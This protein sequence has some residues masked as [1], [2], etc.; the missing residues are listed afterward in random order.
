MGADPREAR[1]LK[2]R[3]RAVTPKREVVPG[4]ALAPKWSI[5][6]VWAFLLARAVVG[7]GGLGRPE[8]PKRPPRAAKGVGVEA[9]QN[10]A[11]SVARDGPGAGAIDTEP[12]L[13]VGAGPRKYARG[14][15]ATKA[16]GGRPGPRVGPAGGGAAKYLAV[17][18]HLPRAALRVAGP[19]GA[20]CAPLAG[21]VGV[22]EGAR[23]A[24]PLD[25][26]NIAPE[27]RAEADRRGVAGRVGGIGVGG[28]A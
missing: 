17:T 7:E 12:T 25:A 13:A 15:A 3:P 11:P 28:A 27:G 10:A 20:A 8:D 9:P 1:G 16:I 4:Q 2:A 5:V 26:A 18:L 24:P 21:P 14:R 6:A 23:Q 19:K 22:P